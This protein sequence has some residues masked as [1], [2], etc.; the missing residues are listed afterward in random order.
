M[1]YSNIPLELQSMPNWCVF[2]IVIDEKEN[3]PKKIIV[4]PIT[5]KFAKSNNPETWSTFEQALKYYKKYNYDGL[6]F[7]LSEGLTFIDLDHVINKETNEIVSK[8]ALE[9][10]DIFKETYT[11]KSVSNTGIHILIKGELADSALK[12]NDKLG[13]EMYSHNRFICMTGE[14][15]VQNT[16]VK[17]Y[18]EKIGSVNQQYIGKTNTS[19][20]QRIPCSHSD[21]ELLKKIRASRI[22]TKFNDLYSGRTDSFL[23]PSSADFALCSILAWW[24]QDVSQIDRIF[25]SSGLYRP[26][27]DTSRGT[28]TYGELT[29]ARALDSLSSTYTP[30]KN[31]IRITTDMEM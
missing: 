17:D 18:S 5:H 28:I 2:K 21:N 3:K 15:L 14:L 13:I 10:L 29:I 7:A 8:E 24:T 11:E 9:L 19:T 4:S 23:S 25:R 26:K 30:K 22:A 31:T 16:Q 12:R 27:W 6:V 1:N 20:I